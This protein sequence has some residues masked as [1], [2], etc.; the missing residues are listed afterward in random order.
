[1]L[2]ILAGIVLPRTAETI[3]ILYLKRASKTVLLYTLVFLLVVAIASMQQ[4]DEPRQAVQAPPPAP[5]AVPVTSPPPP[6]ELPSPAPV[7]IKGAVTLPTPAAATTPGLATC[8]VCGS[9]LAL[10]TN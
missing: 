6:P 5:G 9:A 2:L 1:L 8:P 4:A 3:V 10:R 7:P